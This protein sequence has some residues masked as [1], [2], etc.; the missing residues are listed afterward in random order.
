MRF[1][2]A[3]D[4][5]FHRRNGI[6]TLCGV[7]TYTQKGESRDIDPG[8]PSIFEK[9]GSAGSFAGVAWLWDNACTVA[10]I[11]LTVAVASKTGITE[12]RAVLDWA[13]GSLRVRW[14][15]NGGFLSCPLSIPTHA[16]T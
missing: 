12:R 2:R 16:E 3:T 7:V 14:I 10:R 4:P 13:E 9:L 1:A 6:P 15:T 8:V 11:W 5:S